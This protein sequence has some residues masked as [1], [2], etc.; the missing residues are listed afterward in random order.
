MPDASP[1]KWHRAHT[2]WFFETFVL[3]PRGVA[4]YDP[5]FSLLFNSYYE[6]VGP[7]HPRP[8]RGLLSR[9]DAS[10]VTAYRHLVDGRV[11]ELLQSLSDDDF[12][13]TRP[14]VE[15]GLNHE[16]QHQELLLT[17][18]QHAFAQNPLRPAYQPAAPHVGAEPVPLTFVPFDGGLFELGAVS[19]AGFAFDNEG[20]RHKA[21]L[22]P[23][24]LSS[25]LVCVA[26][27]SE[28]VHAGGYR[29]ASLWLSEGWEFIRA[30]GIEAPLFGR[31]D[32]G[33]FVQFGLDGE[34]ERSAADP[35]VHVS[36]YEADAIARF[37][38]ARLPTEAE[39]E[40][41]AAQCRAQP[42]LPVDERLRPSPLG[43]A[44]LTQL[45]GAA[46]QWTASAYAAYPGYRAAPGALG[47][48]NGKFMVGQMVLR[49]SSLFTPPGHSRT[50]YRNFWPANTRFQ[51]TGIRLARDGR[52]S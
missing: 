48:Y 24:S 5:R 17:D 6:A 18:I 36:Y 29:T 12:E 20:P 33:A 9:P 26:E 8:Q 50:S 28:F 10:E 39:W 1:T 52:I 3:E 22:E 19:D 41:A 14:I 38:D 34:H 4:A 23:F 11:V 30:H 37:L 27:L 16:E 40:A 43:Q 32:A 25:R 2:T 21:W 49:G 15:L 45:F 42:A 31:F 51:M 46:W 47:E 44:E 35:L 13:V 7:R